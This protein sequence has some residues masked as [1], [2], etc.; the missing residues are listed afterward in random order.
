MWMLTLFDLP[1]KT[2]I[3]RRVYHQLRLGLLK[4]G[5]QMIQ[6]SVYGRHC[7]SEENADVHEKRVI[8]LLPSW[9]EVRIIM[10]TDKQFERMRVF[11]GTQKQSPESPPDQLTFF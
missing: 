11:Y 7:P 5:F 1:T 3:Q 9:G 6:Y 8:T 10:L 4:D 2:K